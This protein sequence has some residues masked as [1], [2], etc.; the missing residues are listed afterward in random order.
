[1]RLDTVVA[2][3]EAA[4]VMV[5]IVEYDCRNV[6]ILSWSKGGFERRIEVECL[7]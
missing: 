7:D 6:Y 2:A 1:M 3:A 5:S 4:L